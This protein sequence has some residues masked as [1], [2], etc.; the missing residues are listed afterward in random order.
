M[1]AARNAGQPSAHARRGRTGCAQVSAAA[2]FLLWQVARV[3]FFPPE[4]RAACQPRCMPMYAHM[5]RIS[6]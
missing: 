4:R 3:G 5:H 6:A 2:R 1:I